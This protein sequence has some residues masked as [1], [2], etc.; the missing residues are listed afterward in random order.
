MS[1]LS[2]YVKERGMVNLP[3]RVGTILHRFGLSEAK[4][5]MALDAYMQVTDR[6]ECTPTFPVTT[7][8]L[9]RSPGTIQRLRDRG[10]ELAVHGY[11][12]TDY[13]SLD[14][15][16]Q[17]RH[18]QKACDEFERH[19]IPF[20]G[21]RCPYYRWNED[22]WQ[23]GADGGFLYSSN[24]VAHWDCVK[25]DDFA[26]SQWASYQKAL[27]LY[28]SRP[29]ESSVLLPYFVKGMVEIPVSIPDDE[30][31]VERLGV[32][33]AEHKAKI[34]SHILAGTYERGEIFTLSLHP[35]RIYHCRE[36]LDTVLARARDMNPRVWIASLTQVDAWWRERATFFLK[37][38]E[39][40]PGLYGVRA[41][42]SS[43]G[44]ILVR[45]ARVN[46]STQPWYPP[47]SIVDAREFEVESQVRPFIGLHPEAPQSLVDFLQ[48]EGHVVERSSNR[49]AYGVYLDGSSALDEE[50]RRA[51]I[52]RIERSP[53][54]LVRLWRWPEGARSCL[55]V[56]GDI[57]SIKLADFFLRPF[58]A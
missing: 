58:E 23:V 45:G 27:K 50:G 46:K 41:S 21:F 54:P 49:Q 25:A 29:A 42:T 14:L 33:S 17:K 38:M 48:G 28:S 37:G 5:A 15:M 2:F 26:P 40:A 4:M 9:K 44:T 11:V 56:T 1:M 7:I 16:V 52:D 8:A 51:I 35:E 36:A 34:W 13:G 39:K 6:Y 18:I 24:R 19:G 12:H 10:A 55:A 3:R 57:D 32:A 53:A 22:T 30:A 20:S 43:R 31:L 47:Y